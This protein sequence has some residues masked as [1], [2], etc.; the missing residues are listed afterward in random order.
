MYDV[1]IDEEH[2]PGLFGKGS[3]LAELVS[4]VCNQILKAKQEKHAG[5]QLYERTEE[6]RTY[7]N[8]YQERT[9]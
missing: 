9:I 2:V 7:R 5:A 8:G 1:S 3:K 4:L 6:R